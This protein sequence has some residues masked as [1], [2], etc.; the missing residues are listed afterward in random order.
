MNAR[1]FL[2]VALVG[3][4]LL[5]PGSASAANI[6]FDGTGGSPVVNP[7]NNFDVTPFTQSTSGDTTTFSGGYRASDPGISP[8]SQ[9]IYFTDQGGTVTSDILTLSWTNDGFDGV[10]F[11]INISGSWSV[12]QSQSV[13]VGAGDA[14]C[15]KASV[16]A[17]VAISSACLPTSRWRPRQWQRFPNRRL[18]R[19]LSAAC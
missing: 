12:N 11:D 1:W 7:D 13:P 17:S 4:W 6:D 18:S 10:F 15:P 3:L 14:P 16:G 2:G 5:M 8:G 9:T 19:W